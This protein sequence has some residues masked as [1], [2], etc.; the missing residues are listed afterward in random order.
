MHESRVESRTSKGEAP[1]LVLGPDA[2]LRDALERELRALRV[3]VVS[4]ATSA[5]GLARLEAIERPPPVV[6]LPEASID[7]ET[8]EAELAEIRIRSGSNRLVPIAIGRAPDEERRRALR[9]AGIHLALFAPF[10]RHALR[11]QINRALSAHAGRRPRGER[12]APKE[13]RTRSFSSGR[14]KAV[15]CYSLSSRGAY[16]VAPRPWV[17]GS[18][19]ELDVRLGVEE[20]RVSGRILY[21]NATLLATRSTLP[22]GM[23]VAFD[24][25]DAEL[26]EAIRHDIARTQV[27]LEV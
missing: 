24:P 17:V 18:G 19:V 26:V 22:R 6:M 25:L 5:E 7:P 20:A 9:D 23:A 3:R 16:L 10:G 2:R 27:G 8:F 14:E 4:A 15:R 11:F 21:T 13:W 1:I 12:R